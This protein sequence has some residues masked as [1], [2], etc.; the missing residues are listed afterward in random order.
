M[1]KYYRDSDIAR[2]MGITRKTVWNR[3]AMGAPMPPHYLKPGLRK[4]F[5]DPK[6]VAEW[7]KENNFK[8]YIEHFLKEST[9]DS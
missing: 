4:R 8:A 9:R 1:D 5:Y 3:F 2:F 7:F 6:A